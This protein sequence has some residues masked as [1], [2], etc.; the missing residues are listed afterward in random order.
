MALFNPLTLC[1]PVEN[2]ERHEKMLKPSVED[3]NGVFTL[4]N[5]ANAICD[6]TWISLG[7]YAFGSLQI[8]GFPN[9]NTGTP[10]TNVIVNLSNSP[11]VPNSSDHGYEWITTD[12]DRIVTLA[13]NTK[14]VKVRVNSYGGGSISAYAFVVSP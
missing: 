4:L 12:R 11:T 7:E 1:S 13:F 8:V 2:F 6:G 5:T 3:N 9:S 10:K 14:W